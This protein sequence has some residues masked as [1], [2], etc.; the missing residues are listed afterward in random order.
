MKKIIIT[1]LTF[2]LLSCVY[3]QTAAEKEI[4]QLEMEQKEA[5]FKKDT[6]TLFRLFSPGVIVHGPSN[7]I[8]TLHDL[9]VRI[10]KGGSDRE[11][12]DRVIEKITFADNIAIVM[13]N[14][15][16]KPTGIAAHAG[17]T[18]KRRYTNIWMKNNKS[19]QLVAR[20]STIISME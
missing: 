9:L 20:Q 12:Y 17:K 11:L 15:T 3:A 8:E 16:I 5:Y 4:Q 10:R 18:V 13:G 1:S 2:L 7:K 19:W 6:T 14:E